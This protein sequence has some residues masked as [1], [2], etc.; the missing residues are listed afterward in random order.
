MVD[1]VKLVPLFGYEESNSDDAKGS[2]ALQ[3][4]SETFANLTTP[5]ATLPEFYSF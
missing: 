2:I 3:S 5:A 4:R 1:A